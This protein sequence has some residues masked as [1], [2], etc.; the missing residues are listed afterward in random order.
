MNAATYPQTM[1]AAKLHHYVPQAYL[2]RFGHNNQVKVRRRPRGATHRSHVKNVAAETGFYTVTANDGTTSTIIEERLSDLESAGIQ[3]MRRID[4]GGE[5]PAIGSDDR[6]TLCLYLAVQ[7]ARTP[8]K[9]TPVLFSHAVATYAGGRTVDRRLIADYLERRHLG[10][11]PSTAE[12]EGAWTYFHSMRTQIGGNPQNAAISATLGP[13]AQYLR[14]FRA[15]HWCL[16][17]CRK[18][19]FLTSDAPLVLWWP[20]SDRDNH[21]GV[22]LQDADEI[23]F[24]LDLYKQLVLTPGDGNSVREV[25]LSRAVACNQDLADSCERVIVGHPDRDAWLDRPELSERGPVLRFNFAPLFDEGPDGS[26]QKSG[27]DVLHVWTTRR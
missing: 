9:R 19:A 5:L 11:E 2:A 1:S 4:E 10:R 18:P 24:P 3:A 7:M 20:P 26:R 12:V 22:G 16:E 25:K 6:E 27:R 13:I 15:R 8:R 14:Y 21:R 17:T 23:R